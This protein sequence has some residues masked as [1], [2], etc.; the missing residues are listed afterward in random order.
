MTVPFEKR[1]PYFEDP[2]QTASIQEATTFF[3]WILPPP[4]LPLIIL[5]MIVFPMAILSAQSLLI[6]LLEYLT[7]LVMSGSEGGSVSLP[8]HFYIKL[9]A[10][11]V[12]VS[13]GLI[14]LVLRIN[15]YYYSAWAKG[16]PKPHPL[17]VAYHPDNQQSILSLLNW[18]LYR[19]FTIF[20]PP[21]FL[22]ALTFGLGLLELYLFN[23]STGFP[24]ISLSIQFIVAIFLMMLL[25]L[26]TGFSLINSSWTF[27]TTVFGDLIAITEP[28]LSVK[29]IFD[30]CGRI[31][32][33]S[34]MIFI[35]L[36]A[37][38]AF[39]LG[40][41]G[42]IYFLVATYDIQDLLK[43]KMNFPLLLGAECVTFV[44]YITINYLRFYTYHMALS[45]F[46]NK[47]P[48]NLKDR[49]SSQGS[50]FQY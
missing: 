6:P 44:F 24:F 38:G 27:L 50:S 1:A 35:F 22:T 9:G 8:L 2:A 30:R 21:L 14:Q 5:L 11:L 18:K 36:I 40:F 41:L 25:S 32:F 34:P 29:T 46:Y 48:P 19:L 26:F 43:F 31:V 7:S 47:L 37:Y 16:F 17:H 42:E 39:I 28:D 15:A 45:N 49:Y 20:A 3:D 12:L 33:S 4:A 10:F 13:F 23:L